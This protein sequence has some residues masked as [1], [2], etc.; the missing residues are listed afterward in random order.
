MN[1]WNQSI[2]QSKDRC[3]SLCSIL[4]SEHTRDL[5]SFRAMRRHEVASRC[6]LA[7]AAFNVNRA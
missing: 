4:D 5:A 1:R 6:V 3:I 2:N 7:D